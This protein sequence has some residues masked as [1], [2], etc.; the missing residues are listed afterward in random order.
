VGARATVTPPSGTITLPEGQ[1]R[2]SADR[3][4]EGRAVVLASE[5]AMVLVAAAVYALLWSLTAPWMIAADSWMTFNDGRQVAEQGIP[6]HISMTVLGHGGA[7]I[8]QQWLAQIFYWWVYRVGGLQLSLLSM[9]V[10]LLAP[11]LVAVAVARK[12]GASSVVVIPFLLLPLANFSSI[13]R[14][15][16]FSPI[17]FVAVVA[18]L[19][20]QSHRKSAQVFV[21]VPALVLW[22]NLHGAAIIGAALMS[23]LGLTELPAAVAGRAW[24]PVRRATA[25]IVL[26]VLCLLATPYGLGTVDYY[27]ETISNPALHEFEKEWQAPTFASLPGFPLFVL[28]AVTLVLVGKRRRD[29]TRFE[30]GVLAVTLVAAVLSAR[31]IP[32]FL[33]AALMFIPPLA[34]RAWRR[35]APSPQPVGPALVIAATAT[36]VAIAA[37]ASVALRSTSR[38]EGQWPRPAVAAVDSVL[39]SDSHA[40]VFASYEYADWLLFVSRRARGRVAFNGH[41]E[42]LSQSQLRSALRYLD[43]S[44]PR[45]RAVARGYRVVVLNPVTEKPLINELRRAPSTRVLYSG[46]TVVVLDRSATPEVPM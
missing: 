25:L 28:A 27:R 31:S 45:W 35:K 9:F 7:W 2:R 21:L 24:A 43:Q 41:L 23:L 32:W 40:R 46:S 4:W 11:L 39:E 6:H 12:R 8:D 17:L 37:L 20:A 30:I 16:V 5:N 10:L 36:I 13:L 44:G 14:A 42:L 33:Y 15:Q 3:S 22:A 38:L 1:V 19:A 29:L 34:E 18:V 26:P